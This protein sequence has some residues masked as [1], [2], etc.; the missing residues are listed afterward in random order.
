MNN[1]IA[2]QVLFDR[3]LCFSVASAAI[4]LLFLF[5]P[6]NHYLM[7]SLYN[8]NYYH[9]GVPMLIAAYFACRGFRDGIEMTILILYM[10]WAVVTRVLNGDLFLL[11]EGDYLIDLSTMI[12][13]FAPGILLRGKKREWYFRSVSCI[14]IVF[15][16]AASLVCIYAAATNTY[17]E[18]PIDFRGIGYSALTENRFNFLS[19]QWNETAGQFAI[20]FALSLTLFFKT[21]RLPIQA[22]LTVAAFCDAVVVG[23]TM[24]RNGQTCVGLALGMMFGILIL[25][26]L[27]TLKTWQRTLILLLTVVITT[28][29]I[30]HFFEPIRYGIWSIS[31]S[32]QTADATL[33]AQ[34]KASPKVLTAQIADETMNG[35]KNESTPVGE[36]QADERD[37]FESGRK[38][39]YWSAL[40]SLQLEPKRLV[41]GS[42]YYHVMDISH[43]LIREQA[44]HFHNTFLQ[45]INEFGMI[46]FILVLWFFCCILNA[47]FHLTV[48]PAGSVSVSDQ[49][50]VLVP[51]MLMFYYML[52]VGIFKIVDMANIRNTV[53]YFACGMLT[54][55]SRDGNT[56]D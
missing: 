23:L 45:V 6:L 10:L 28:V 26:R 14:L 35:E 22:F 5:G 25:N 27:K 19:F 37:Y 21:K 56:E 42:G 49:I 38:E 52:E 31:Q 7:E 4:M 16:F 39:I 11:E 55:V 2:K 30:Y 53:F 13:M 12:L 48:V 43:Q 1:R 41:I 44:K 3:R 9:L 15:Y 51:L 47:A 18:N 24:S 40:K 54:G 29:V 20:A 50:L 8:S 32:A 17:L 34:T 33:H 36:Y 46:G